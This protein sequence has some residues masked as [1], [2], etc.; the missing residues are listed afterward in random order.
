M[1]LLAA[2]HVITKPK[3]F[4]E[5]IAKAVPLALEGR[6][7]TFGIEPDGPETGYGYIKSGDALPGGFLLDSFREKP[8]RETAQEYLNEGGYSWNSGIFLLNA[9]SFLD[10]LQR[11]RPDIA[12]PVSAAWKAATLA[13]RMI[14]P[15]AKQWDATEKDSIDYAVAEKT[16]GGAVVP[17]S[18][19][20]SDVGSWSAI[21][22]LAQKDDAR[23][24]LTGKAVAVDSEG[25]L[26][27]ASDSRVIALAGCE[28]LIVVDTGDT[29]FIAPKS[30]VQKVK[31]LVAELKDKGF[32]ELL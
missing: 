8:N 15:D 30:E 27:R 23:N 28:D 24:A 13:D 25:C 18:M 5:A 14:T 6:L 19:G 4:H 31:A 2:D 26:V 21:H 29:V 17:V 32:D 12:E 10:E 20:W 3:A 11:L 22:D 9:R 16:Q 7:V 1:L